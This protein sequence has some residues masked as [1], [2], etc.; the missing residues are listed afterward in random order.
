MVDVAEEPVKQINEVYRKLLGYLLKTQEPGRV[1][2][3]EKRPLRENTFKDVR[4]GEEPGESGS[5]HTGEETAE[6]W[7]RRTLC[8]DEGCIGVIGADGRCKECGRA[9]DAMPG[10]TGETQGPS[11]GEDHAEEQVPQ[12]QGP[13]LAPSET[14]GWEGRTLCSDGS[15]IGVIGPDGRCKECGKPYER[16]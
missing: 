13:V 4:G 3:T 16:I 1:P 12:E 15:C 14:E 11:L 5:F 10:L 7:E 2:T 8:A 9:L 6:D